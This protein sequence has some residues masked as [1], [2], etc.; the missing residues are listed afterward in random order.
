MQKKREGKSCGVVGSS[1]SH[2][3]YIFTVREHA[4]SK[5]LTGRGCWSGVGV[6]VGVDVGGCGGVGVL[7]VLC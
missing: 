6:G 5:L 4:T 7:L 1:K 3:I 2:F